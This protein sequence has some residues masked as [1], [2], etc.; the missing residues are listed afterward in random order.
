MAHDGSLRPPREYGQKK[1]VCRGVRLLSP[2][3]LLHIG[4]THAF[5]SVGGGDGG[6]STGRHAPRGGTACT[7]LTID[8]ALLT[9]LWG[10][11]Y[12][13][14][15]KEGGGA[16]GLQRAG[17]SGGGGV[18]SCVSRRPSPVMSETP[19]EGPCSWPVGTMSSVGA[20]R[21]CLDGFLIY[22]IAP[23][24]LRPAGHN[25]HWWREGGREGGRRG[26]VVC[27]GYTATSDFPPTLGTT[28]RQG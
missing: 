2:R 14:D 18:G 15:A 17:A 23:K 11:T 24:G 1:R 10:R 26:A 22:S 27:R 28:R 6:A 3:F 12:S 5:E 21:E 9:C 20:H 16:E 8:G 7:S 19:G 25:G 4:P 13:R